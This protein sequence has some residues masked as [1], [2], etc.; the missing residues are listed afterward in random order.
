MVVLHPY[1]GCSS[2]THILLEHRHV[3]I[4]PLG[5]LMLAMLMSNPSSFRLI[6]TCSVVRAFSRTRRCRR[7]SSHIIIA[8]TAMSTTSFAVPLAPTAVTSFAP[9]QNSLTSISSSPDA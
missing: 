2:Q 5:R 8:S 6:P 3:L 4:T 7:S 1:M 9:E